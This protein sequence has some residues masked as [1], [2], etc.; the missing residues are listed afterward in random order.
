MYISRNISLEWEHLWNHIL[1]AGSHPR[2][3]KGPA[4]CSTKP[5]GHCHSA[6]RHRQEPVGS[7]NGSRG[8]D[9]N[10]DSQEIMGIY[11]VYIHNI[12]IYLYI[13]IYLFIYDGDITTNMMFGLGT[14]KW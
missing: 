12:Y 6:R 13:Y 11:I 10:G 14:K 8:D 2:S 4:A 7:I 1:P 9:R 5:Q 3:V